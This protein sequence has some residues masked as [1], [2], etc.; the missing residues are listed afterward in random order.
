M[1]DLSADD[2]MPLEIHDHF[3]DLIDRF[4]E[5]CQENKFEVI[6]DLVGEVDPRYQHRLTIE[7]LAVELEF[8]S[9]AGQPRHLPDYIERFPEHAALVRRLT[10]A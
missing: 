7:L 3:V 10:R 5:A 9:K 4:E 1:T 8:R 2:S 6:Q